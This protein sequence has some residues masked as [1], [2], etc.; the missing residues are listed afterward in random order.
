MLDLTGG[1]GWELARAAVSAWDPRHDGPP[2]PAPEDAEYRHAVMQSEVHRRLLARAVEQLDVYELARFYG[3][4]SR[5]HLASRRGCAHRPRDAHAA[6]RRDRR[7]GIAMRGTRGRGR[8]MTAAA[9]PRGT[10]GWWRDDG[11][12]SPTRCPRVAR[13]DGG[14]KSL[15]G[16]AGGTAGPQRGAARAP[17]AARSNGCMRRSL[18]GTYTRTR[19]W[20]ARRPPRPTTSAWIRGS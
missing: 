17:A 8:A 10:P 6:R 16:E 19:H 9:I 13:D 14:G 1:V 5:R 18:G 15:R 20:Q 12:G 3:H 11:G 2:D 7:A 4:L